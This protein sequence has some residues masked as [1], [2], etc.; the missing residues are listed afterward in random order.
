[1]NMR[2]IVSYLFIKNQTNE[3]ST[4]AADPFSIECVNSKKQKLR[5]KGKKTHPETELKNIIIV[6]RIF[7]S[8][9]LLRKRKKKKTG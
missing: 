5:E 6:P 2:P 7:R 4:T 8:F 3:L 1:M 9:T